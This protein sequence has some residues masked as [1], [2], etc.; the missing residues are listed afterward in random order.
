[1][2][3][4]LAAWNESI[5]KEEAVISAIVA[6]RA[7]MDSVVS[8]RIKKDGGVSRS[9]EIKIRS[10][11]TAQVSESFAH[12]KR[13]VKITGEH[14]DRGI[15]EQWLN[16]SLHGGRVLK[17][18]TE[19][20]A[21]IAIT[22]GTSWLRPK[23]RMR[24]VREGEAMS[25]HGMLDYEILSN[26]QVI[27]DTKATSIGDSRFLIIQRM[28]NKSEMKA[29]S[30]NG[31]TKKVDAKGGFTSTYFS[32]NDHNPDTDGT[33]FEL[34]R[35]IEFWTLV[36]RVKVEFFD[37]DNNK[38]LSAEEWEEDIPIPVIPI[39][40][41][42]EPSRPR[43]TSLISI[44][45]EDS[46]M[47]SEL[48]AGVNFAFH[49]SNNGIK[50]ING[51]GLTAEV[52]AQIQ[53]GQEYV[54]APGIEGLIQASYPQVPGSVF[55]TMGMLS[56]EMAASAG[57]T[58]GTSVEATKMAH[59]MPTTIGEQKIAAF[60]RGV[61]D[62]IA[63]A[64]KVWIGFA[65]DGLHT[66]QIIQMYP[67]IPETNVRIFEEIN[68]ED[69]SV[70][71]GSENQ[72]NKRLFYVSQ[73][74]QH[75]KSFERV[76]SNDAISMIGAEFYQLLGLDEVADKIMQGKPKA[77]IEAEQAAMAQQQQLAVGAETAKIQEIYSKI[78]DREVRA[79]IDAN[80]TAA[81]VELKQA[82]ANE[83]R[84]SS[85]IKENQIIKETQAMLSPYAKTKQQN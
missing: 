56:Q 38:L 54:L 41:E 12:L 51:K 72:R 13:P 43:G 31:K 9:E 22:D 67:S 24:K 68:L 59:D 34:T 66:D 82:K 21:N 5:D 39:Q 25:D 79:N 74:L 48:K 36:G 16:S 11:L 32:N 6:E 52:I 84:A 57:V 76:M 33:D 63:L 40:Y 19:R 3:N 73:G 1:M 61:E 46:K 80:E 8:T 26:E 49:S 7:E 20:L 62:A 64:C 28:M 81:E 10:M 53:N 27:T 15:I 44:I 18:M 55:S 14:D 4:L 77:E 23:W 58:G 45:G 60:I 69:V 17:R 42:V 70:D 78:K 2:K 83:V 30:A 37:I 65:R 35:V 85:G 50:F 29:L 71:I 47:K 75:T